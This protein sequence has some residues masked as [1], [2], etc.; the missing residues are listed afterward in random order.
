MNDLSVSEQ[1]SVIRA[2]VARS[3]RDTAESGRFF[4]WLGVVALVG[5]AVIAS[6]EQAG[7]TGLVLPSLVTMA[8]VSGIVG[9]LTL[10]RARKRSGARSYAAAVSAFVWFGVGTVALLVAFVLP[11]VGAYGWSLAPVLTC[12]VLGIGV[13]STGA[14]FEVPTVAWCA[15]AWWI[16]G[17]GIV[18][19]EGSPRAAIMACAIGVGWILPGILFG[20]SSGGN[21]TDA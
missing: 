3:R 20:R 11:L 12:L 8:V 19:V 5:V 9:Y 10:A 15:L 7:R 1:L 16:A 4:V 6:L 14:I 2:M 18:F 17:V 13:F 21:D